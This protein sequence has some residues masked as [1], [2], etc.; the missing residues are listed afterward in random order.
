MVHFIPCKKVN[1]AVKTP[2]LFF[3]EVVLLHEVHKT[4]MSDMDTF[5]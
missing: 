5:V 1:D 3:K 2:E 4:I